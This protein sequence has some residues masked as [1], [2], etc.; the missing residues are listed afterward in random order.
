VEVPLVPDRFEALG[1]G[2]AVDV[3]QV[4]AETLVAAEAG[5]N[6]AVSD[7][8]LRFT[9]YL[10]TQI[11]LSAREKD[12]QAGLAEQGIH[13]APDS[14]VFDLT[15]EVQRAIDEHVARHGRAT[16]ISEMAQQAAGEAIAS[17]AGPGRR[18]D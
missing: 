2:Q 4:A 16:T 7:Q 17:L 13:L 12:W 11:V 15:S 18:P 8:G 1:V 6:A 14:S 3:P 10:M 5:L 9:F